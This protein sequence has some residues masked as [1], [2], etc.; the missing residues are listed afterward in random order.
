MFIAVS[1]V[2]GQ[3]LAAGFKVSL[4]QFI[5][6]TGRISTNIEACK[7]GHRL[8]GFSKA[9]DPDRAKAEALLELCNAGLEANLID[10]SVVTQAIDE[11]E[12]APSPVEV[13]TEG[14]GGGR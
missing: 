11:H 1:P 3:I 13:A 6:P 4:H 14:R 8:R 7:D 9:T 10:V 5:D 12:A 2:I